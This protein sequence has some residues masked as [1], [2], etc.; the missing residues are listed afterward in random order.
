MKKI[1]ILLPLLFLFLYFSKATP[2]YAFTVNL[3]TDNSG[4]IDWTI[5]TG[6]NEVQNGVT[7]YDTL[8]H[9][10]NQWEG[11]NEYGY[12]TNG[13]QN[14][15]WQT[16]DDPNRTISQDYQ[17]N[18]VFSVFENENTAYTDS[19]GHSDMSYAPYLP[20][21]SST[22]TLSGTLHANQLFDSN[23]NHATEMTVTLQGQSS[24]DICNFQIPDSESVLYDRANFNG[25]LGDI[26]AD[27]STATPIILSSLTNSVT[28]FTINQDTTTPITTATFSP[29]PN[30]NGDYSG[31]VTVTL[32]ATP[33]A[34]YSLFHTFY[35]IDGGAQQTYITPFTIS[36]GGSH[37]ITYYSLDTD[38][39]SETLNTQTI[40]VIVNSPPSVGAISF[41]NNPV[42]INNATTATATFT[43]PAGGSSDT[44]Q[45][46]W[47][48][49]NTTNG[50]VT[51]SN[52]SGSVTNTHTYTSLGSYTVTL[53]VTNNANLN[54]TSQTV[55]A[56]EPSG[57]FEG[58]NLNSANYSGANLSNQNLSS[59]NLQNA[60][61]NNTNLTD[62]NLSGDNAK[63][64]S[65]DGANLT[66][67]N[68]TGGNFQDVNF[69]SANLT[70]ADLQGDNLKGSNMTGANLSGSNMSS[71]NFQD[72]NFT[73]A[74]LTRANLSGS[75]I[76]GTTWSNTTCPDGTN[77]NNDGDTCTGH[78]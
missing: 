3:N 46:N 64:A 55:V 26:F 70:N 43:D 25:Q 61:F 6:Q 71:G 27:P 63:G 42:K 2:A 40:D 75:N 30:S 53:T 23:G 44:A 47:G 35:T 14:G 9:I 51:E 33:A 62:A 58:G 48:D 16:C 54:G 21:D 17:W 28:T 8:A 72:I 19:T 74:N 41:S 13:V 10:M 39:E 73:N 52:G 22:T 60:T 15:T 76:K 50:T 4:N 20:V 49:G 34:G 31:P 37:T 32:S 45:W 66:G 67:A 36:T 59:G 65:F 38:G 69:T 5:T 24:D 29:S 11:Y 68:L 12:E 1:A 56:V 7:T 78:L 57:G 77:S 18:P